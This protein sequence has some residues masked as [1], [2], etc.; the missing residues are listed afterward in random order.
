MDLSFLK[1]SSSWKHEHLILGT[2]SVERRDF[3]PDLQ[4]KCWRFG[5]EVVL[6]RALQ[7]VPKHAFS[8]VVVC[9]S[10]EQN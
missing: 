5:F 10:P 1:Q 6:D 8:A 7:N 4:E 2:S 9:K 3:R